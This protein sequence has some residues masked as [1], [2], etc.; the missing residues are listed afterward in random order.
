MLPG[1]KKVSNYKNKL[2]LRPHRCVIQ[3]PTAVPSIIST[4]ELLITLY[5][6]Y[7][8]TLGTMHVI[9]VCYI[10][11]SVG[12]FCLI[13]CMTAVAERDL[14]S[15]F[16]CQIQITNSLS[17]AFQFQIQFSANKTHSIIWIYSLQIQAPLA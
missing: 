14:T 3:F 12:A 1:D 2:D 6:L 9:Y 10:T 4:F 16:A 7:I 8:I 11:V 5:V 15:K 13:L 17:I